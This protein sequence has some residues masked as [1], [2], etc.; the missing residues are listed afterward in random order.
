MLADKGP[1]FFHPGTTGPSEPRVRY[2]DT[3]YR[4]H[5]AQEE[6]QA[7]FL[8]LLPTLCSLICLSPPTSPEML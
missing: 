8:F 6:K 3:F 2:G 1:S 5:S 7:F 4:D